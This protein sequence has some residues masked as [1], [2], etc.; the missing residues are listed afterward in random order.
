MKNRIRNDRGFTLVEIMAVVVIIGLLVGAAAF[1]VLPKILRTEQTV[2]KTEIENYKDAVIEFR[3]ECG[4]YPEQ[5][6][7]LTKKQDIS[8]G[9]TVGP[10]MDKIKLDPWGNE[11]DYSK[12]NGSDFE[13]KSFGADG[14]EGGEEENKDISNK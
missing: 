8:N 7:E 10:W 6:I 4:Y 14:S 9:E 12:N 11:Y 3:L 2:A 5:L 13:I 1:V